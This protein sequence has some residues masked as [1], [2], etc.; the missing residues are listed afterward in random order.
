MTRQAKMIGAIMCLTAVAP[1]VAW[2]VWKWFH[3][4]PVSPALFERTRAAVE[5]DPRPPPAW[6]G[7]MRDGVLT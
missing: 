4:K 3:P 1:L 2:P 5:K 7:V 6:D